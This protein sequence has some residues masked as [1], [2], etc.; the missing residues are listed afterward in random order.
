MFMLR[1][2]ATSESGRRV[3]LHA[4]QRPSIVI[5]IAVPEILIDCER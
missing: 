1:D 2:L 5:N 4:F 3:L